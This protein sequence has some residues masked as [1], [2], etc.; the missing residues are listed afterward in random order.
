[1]QRSIP[2][3]QGISEGVLESDGYN[4]FRP[5]SSLGY[6]PPTAEAILVSGLTVDWSIL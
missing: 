5:H 4:Q 1:M 2:V 6:K 3:Y